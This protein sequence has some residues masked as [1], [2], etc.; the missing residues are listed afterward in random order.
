[1]QSRMI[2]VCCKLLSCI[3]LSFVLVLS[4][5]QAVDWPNWRGP[6]YNGISAE[7]GW[8]SDWKT[9]A[10]KKLWEQNVGTGFSSIVTSNGKVFTMG[11]SDDKDSVYAID[12]ETGKLLWQKSYPN[13]LDPEEYEGGPNATPTVDGDRLYTQ[14]KQ[15]ELTCWS[16]NDGKIIWQK[17]LANDLKIKKPKWGF[18]GS[19]LVLDEKLIINVGRHGMALNK[20]TGETI[21]K[22]KDGPSGY[23]TPVSYEQN[24][25]THLAIFSAHFVSG[26][27]SQTGDSLWQQRWKNRWEVNCVDPLV[28]DGKVFASSGGGKRSALIDYKLD[29]PK[30]LWESRQFRVH[31]NPSILHEGHLY[32]FTGGFEDDMTLMCVNFE[33]GKTVWEKSGFIGG[34]MMMADDKLFIMNEGEIILINASHKGYKE[35]SRMKVL[36]GTCWTVPTLSHNRLLARNSEGKLVCYDLR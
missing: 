30:K 36:E 1:M 7:T 21:W 28:H 16:V 17:H 26:V 6:S 11:N 33:T 18:S 20:F 32:G 4:D 13:P 23:A 5:L 27:D 2:Y 34:G 29:K 9:K 22:G 35:I 3:M 31:F 14:S 19:P 24:G 8:N 25:K 15:G 12:F 10:P